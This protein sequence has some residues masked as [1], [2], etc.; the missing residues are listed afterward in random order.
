MNSKRN[1]NRKADV[2]FLVTRTRE[3]GSVYTHLN[4]EIRLDTGSLGDALM[5][6]KW[7]AN[8]ETAGGEWYGFEAVCKTASST[9]MAQAAKL[10]AR[11]A[12]SND[13]AVPSNVLQR[14]VAMG[15]QQVAYDNRVYPHYIPPCDVKNDEYGRWMDAFEKVH[16]VYPGKGPRTE[17]DHVMVST[18]CKRR[19]AE[20]EIARE[21]VERHYYDYL[22]AWV[23]AGK[24]IREDKY[25]TVHGVIE[26]HRAIDLSQEFTDGIPAA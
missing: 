2:Y 13:A 21:L 15:A 18:Q 3:K 10:L 20:Q 23:N 1:T 22:V 25:A 11:I 26:W 12:P 24:P 9:V 19:D 4:V 16:F 6:L 7:Q 14:L 5:E 17:L 8:K